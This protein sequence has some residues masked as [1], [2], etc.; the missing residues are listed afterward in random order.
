MYSV[1][2]LDN[3]KSFV[4]RHNYSRSVKF[5]LELPLPDKHNYVTIK[6]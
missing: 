5:D 4:K 6:I 3:S 2:I 1:K